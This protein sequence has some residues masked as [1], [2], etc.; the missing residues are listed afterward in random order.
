[1]DGTTGADCEL[2]TQQGPVVGAPP[3]H[4]PEGPPL[5]AGQALRL[6]QAHPK[7]ETRH[8][9]GG[10]ENRGPGSKHLAD[11]HCRRAGGGPGRASGQRTLTACGVG[12]Q[13]RV[14]RG[15]CWP[16]YSQAVTLTQGR[17]PEQA[18]RHTR[19]SGELW[20]TTK[21]RQWEGQGTAQG[22][23]ATPRQRIHST[24][25][26]EGAAALGGGG[27]AG[28]ETPPSGGSAS[29]VRGL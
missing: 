29:L 13:T 28:R 18:G 11:P 5:Q 3:A 17:G 20:G 19:R 1:M 4:S 23:R 12:G 16:W 6:H 15:V 27:R 21:G 8:G 2:P 7:E 22:G 10:T 26:S 25:G 9:Y 24:T 14:C